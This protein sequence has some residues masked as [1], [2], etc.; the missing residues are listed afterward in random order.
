MRP[1][2]E[3]FRPLLA[4]ALAVAAANTEGC[5]PARPAETADA[6]YFSAQMDCVEKATTIAQSKAC[7]ADVDRKFGVIQ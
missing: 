3:C 1:L 4:A 2:I 5:V 6:A 7:R